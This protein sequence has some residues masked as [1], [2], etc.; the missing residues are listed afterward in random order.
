MGINNELTVFPA[1]APTNENFLATHRFR[2]LLQR[3]PNVTFFCQEANLP[4]ISMGN[5][6]QPTP[7]TDVP[8]PGDKIQYEDFTISFAVDEDM[9]NYKEVA[10]WITSIGFPRDFRQYDRKN[11]S[12]ISLIIMDSNNEPAHVVTFSDAFPVSLSGIQ[13]NTKADDATPAYA[14]ATFKYAF[15][16]MEQEDV[17][18]DPGRAT[19]PT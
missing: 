10:N 7:F 14:S 4:G 8:V 15:W 1:V 18:A 12:A 13:F 2:I 17:N 11:R 9:N 3:A 6:A 16:S 5:W 19:L